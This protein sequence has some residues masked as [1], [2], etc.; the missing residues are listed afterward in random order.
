MNK[1]IVI[2][3]GGISGLT[4]GVYA[5]KS[6]FDAEIYEKNSIV[7]GECTGWDREGYHIDNCIHWMIG[8][9]EG[10]SL[11]DIWKTIGALEDDLEII[12]SDRM[13][14]SELNGERITLWKDIDRTE[15][16]LIALSP[17]DEAEIKKLMKYVKMAEHTEIPADKPGELMNVIDLIKLGSSMKDMMKLFKELAG[18]DTNDLISCFRHPLIRCMIT[19]FC[20]KDSLAYSFPVTYGNFISGDGGI[21]RGGS[22]AMALRIQK[23]FESLGG[24]VFTNSSAEKIEIGDGG[25]AAGIDLVSGEHIDADYIICACDTDYTFGHLLDKS[26]MNPMFQKMY[27]DRKAFPVYG[28]FQAAFAADSDIDALGGDIMLDCKDI[29]LADWMYDRM[30]IKSYAYEPSFAPDG[31][32]IVQVLIGLREDAYDYWMELHKNKEEYKNKKEELA[33]K[34]LSKLEERFTEYKGKL[35]I[36]DV[37]TPVTYHR[38]CNAYKGYN[39]SFMITK[40]S[41]KNPYP[42]ANIK[43]IDNVILAG[44]WLNPPG[45]LPGAAIQGKYSIQRILKKEGRR[46]N[47]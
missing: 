20:T 26:Y 34:V 21:P 45:G 11:H 30:T 17:E 16:E 8:T 23:K 28:M 29:K 41:G 31:K 22:R 1:K 42:P 15:K 19:D 44:Q 40:Y 37:W 43:G 13:Y 12:Q 32:Q 6:G 2:V 10:S 38:Y 33:N 46:I 36:L 47:I 14:T 39:Q 3:G 24:K 25:K 5:L 27:A 18:K 7:G 35:K 9:K 4:A